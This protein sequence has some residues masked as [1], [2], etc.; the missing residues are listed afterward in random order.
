MAMYYK[1]QLSVIL[2]SIFLTSCKD[3]KG[4]SPRKGSEDL[5]T[6]TPEEVENISKVKIE[7]SIETR[8]ESKAEMTPRQIFELSPDISLK[9][10]ANYLILVT[11]EN[12]KPSEGLES[13]IDN[14]KSSDLESLQ[15]IKFQL[16]DFK[17]L[18]IFATPWLLYYKK[19][20]FV[21]GTFGAEHPANLGFEGRNIQSIK[22]LLKRNN[23]EDVTLTKN[24]SFYMKQKKI[25]N[26]SLENM[27]FSG[28]DMSEFNLR[29]SILSGSNFRNADF[30]NANL[31]HS[32]A[33][34][35]DFTGAIFKNTNLEDTY[36][37]NVTCPNG[38][39]SNDS[40]YSCININSISKDL[41]TT[42]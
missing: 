25:I 18:P 13:T 37:K 26:G 42:D 27:D 38:N 12:C 41:A 3:D 9:P 40:N 6:N 30:T 21:D 33:F 32:I 8:I 20:S 17:A 34:N 16:T 24:V 14:F 5:G 4:L 7:K 35:S 23:N 10:D 15:V 39:L 28:K 11:G 22:N 19:G 36:W 1:I 31:S 29:S 2:T